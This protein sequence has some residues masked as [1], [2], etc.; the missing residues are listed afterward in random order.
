M[1]NDLGR[2]IGKK[3]VM[4]TILCVQMLCV[5]SSDR[6]K[7]ESCACAQIKS[8]EEGNMWFYLDDAG[9]L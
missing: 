4:T 8:V 7:L 5:I 9:D 2:N 1:K 6:I 3:T